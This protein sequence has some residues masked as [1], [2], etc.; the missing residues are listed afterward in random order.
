MRR[1]FSKIAQ[2]VLKLMNSFRFKH[3]LLAMELLA[4]VLIL[5]TTLIPSNPLRMIIG[6]PLFLVFPGYIFTVILFP[7]KDDLSGI[8]LWQ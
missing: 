2:G 7:G 5:L 8:S 1:A 6:F 3:D 4:L